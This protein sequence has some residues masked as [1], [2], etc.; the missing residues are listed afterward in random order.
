MV[1][2]RESRKHDFTN[3][4]RDKIGLVRNDAPQNEIA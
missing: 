4:R 1:K 3:L 2:S